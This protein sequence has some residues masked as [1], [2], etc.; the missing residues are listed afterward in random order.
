MGHG[1]FKPSAEIVNDTA[2]LIIARMIARELS[3]RPALIDEASERLEVMADR[4]GETDYVQM[5]RDL[6]RGDAQSIQRVLRGRD[7]VS[8]WLRLTTPF[9]AKSANIPIQDVNFRR[10]I[11]RDARRLVMMGFGSERAAGYHVSEQGDGA[12]LRRFG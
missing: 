5:W 10:R 11:W 3:R 9:S 8:T 2:K 1:M 6:L 4:N 12:N 7:E